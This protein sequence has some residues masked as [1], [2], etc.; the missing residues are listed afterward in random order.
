MKKKIYSI[1]LAILMTLSFAIPALAAEQNQTAQL[2]RM[3]KEGEEVVLVKGQDGSW[4]TCVLTHTLQLDGKESPA[5]RIQ[6]V[7]SD[8]K[9]KR[10]VKKDNGV[11]TAKDLPYDTYTV[12]LPVS[13]D[14]KTGQG[15]IDNKSSMWG[16]TQSKIKFDE[17]NDLP[18]QVLYMGK[19]RKVGEPNGK[20]YF[21]INRM[22]EQNQKSA[23]EAR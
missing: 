16:E 22:T 12:Y 3:T 9:T 15:K 5:D 4:Y 23:T 13:Y 17:T 6:L 8:K 19:A 11:F 1:L 14:R 2:P 7:S 10:V 21:V 18:E 20:T